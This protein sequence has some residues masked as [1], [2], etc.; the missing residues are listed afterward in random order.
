MEE[1]AV[2]KDSKALPGKDKLG[3]PRNFLRS[4]APAAQAA[5]RQQRGQ[6]PFRFLFE[7]E[8]MALIVRLRALEAA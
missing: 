6:A 5:L 2:R 1:A 3:R 7:V 8:R 4:Q